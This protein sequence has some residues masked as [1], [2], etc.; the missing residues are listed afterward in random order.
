MTSDLRRRLVL[1][2]AGAAL[3]VAASL[4][5]GCG[6]APD[7]TAAGGP[8][9][10]THKSTFGTMPK[11]MAS[12]D[13]PLTDEKIDLG[14]KL[15]Y[16]E[17][18]SVSGDIS[19]NSCHL[20]DE[21][22]A[23]GNATSPGHA[24][25]FGVRNSP[26]VYNAAIHITQFWDGREP[27]VEEQ[28]KGPLLNP[29]EHGFATGEDVEEILRGISGYRP[30]F[31]VA[32][33]GQDEPV[34]FDNAAKAIGAFERKLVTRGKWDRWL[35]GDGSALNVQEVRGLNT[36]TEVG[37]TT[38][39]MG[40]AL[41]GNMYQ[42]MGLLEPYPTEDE[43]RFEVTALEADKFMF[44][45]PTLR[46]VAETAPYMHDGSIDTLDEVVAIMARYQLAKTLTPEQTA[47]IVAFMT[48]LTGKLPTEYIAMPELPVD[49]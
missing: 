39:H 2:L 31:E 23:D 49:G 4:F 8:P 10:A 41:G 46:N 40:P 42:K 32:F 29:V 9:T 38:C 35:I 33:P 25:E 11:V 34:T 19:C 20:L 44:K 27:N 22:G 14:R 36:F 18:L 26:T 43:G 1:V 13:N 37:C 24:G 15:Y 16:D 12:A 45:V 21:F 17:R 47:D 5:G 3:L 7:D 48:V 6:G 28:A 30:L